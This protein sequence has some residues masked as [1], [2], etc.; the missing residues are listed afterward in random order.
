M[1]AFWGRMFPQQVPEVRPLLFM[2]IMV[3]MVIAIS[4]YGEDAPELDIPGG[5]G[6]PIG[7][8]SPWGIYTP[9]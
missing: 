9:R 5:K 2:V 8:P 6:K 1:S 3:I 7:L 4:K